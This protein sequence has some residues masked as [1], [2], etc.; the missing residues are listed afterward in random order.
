MASRNDSDPSNGTSNHFQRRQL[1]CS[2]EISDTPRN[3]LTEV[4][5]SK[6]TRRSLLRGA[7]AVTTGSLIFGTIAGEERDP[8]DI[9]SPKFRGPITGGIR[10]GEPENS[11][12]RDLS[13]WGY[14]EEEYF[15]SG[16][17]M[18]LGPPGLQADTS[19][20]V[21]EV[22]EYTTRMIVWRPE[23]M[24]GSVSP[25]KSLPEDL[26]GRGPPDEGGFSGT[27]VINWP[28]QTL[29][30]DNPV[31]IMNSLEYLAQHGHVGISFSVQKQGVDGSPLGCRWWDPQRYG[32]L[33]HPGDEYSYDILSQG[34]KALKADDRPDDDPLAGHQAERVYAGGVSQSAS[35][36]ANYIN[37]AQEMHDILDGFIPFHSSSVQDIEATDVVP[38]LWLNSEDEVDSSRPDKDQLVLWEVAGASHVNGYTSEWGGTVQARDHGHVAGEGYDPGWDEAEAGQYGEMGSGYCREGDNYTPVRYSLTAAIARLDDHMRDGNPIPSAQRIEQTDDGDIVLDE[39]GNAVGGFRLTTM[40]VPIAT[41]EGNACFRKISNLRGQTLQFDSDTLSGLYDDHDD[42]IRQLE[43]DIEEKIQAGYMQP[44]AGED[45]LRRARRSDIPDTRSL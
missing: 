37:I 30:R 44:W 32:D 34:V 12:P 36:L 3:P 45:L 10:T 22:S 17:A 7:A 13:Q 6:S 29:Q 28:N 8:E 19:D 31:L 39:Y 16:E 14:V 25:G 20:D 41:Y 33:E 43:A 27:I 21:G 11:A 40:D 23:D 42:Y 26:P 35:M 38:I 24:D 9:P 2:D 15:V 4:S 1:L 5:A 18:A